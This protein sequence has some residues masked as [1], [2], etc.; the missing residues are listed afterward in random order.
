MARPQVRDGADSP[1]P[2]TLASVDK[3][4]R[5]GGHLPHGPLWAPRRDPNV[6]GGI[7]EHRPLHHNAGRHARGVQKTRSIVKVANAYPLHL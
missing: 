1:N 4:Q 3:L 6:C 2:S 7:A 5:D